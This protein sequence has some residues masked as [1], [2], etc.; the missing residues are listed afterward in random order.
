MIIALLFG[1]LLMPKEMNFAQILAVLPEG[2]ASHQSI[3]ITLVFALAERGHEITVLT[4]VVPKE[5]HEHVTIL[6][7]DTEDFITNSIDLYTCNDFSLFASFSTI[8]SLNA[9]WSE[10]FLKDANVQKLISSNAH[11]DLVLIDVLGN[12]AHKGFCYHFNA[13]C[14]TI[15]IFGANFW[16]DAQMGNPNNPSY[17]PD[18]HERYASSMSFFQRFHNSFKFVI[19]SINFYWVSLPTQTAIMQRYFPGAPDLKDLFYNVSLSLVNSH[20]TNS[21]VVANLPNVVEIGGLHVRPPQRLPQDVQKFLDD[22]KDG[23]CI[24]AL[25][26]VFSQLKQNVLWKFENESVEMPENIKTVKR[27]SQVDVLAH[28]NIRLFITHGGLLSVTEAIHFGV[29]II[30]IPIFADQK[31]NVKLAEDSGFAISLEYALLNKNVIKDAIE[32]ILTN[33]KFSIAAKTKSKIYHDQ[34][35]KP[36]DRGIYWI[37]Y[38][39]RH[40]GAHHLRSYG[41]NLYWYQY[42]MLDILAV[43]VGAIVLVSLVI[44]AIYRQTCKKIFK[45]KLD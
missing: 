18:R 25:I 24:F 13:I 40:Q 33:S 37:E 10:Q 1:L 30:G 44:K 22:S 20:F 15:N 21:L 7:V 23:L 3:G 34:L 9:Y 11:F 16:L 32:R 45:R 39:I 42:L 27:V 2:V 29:P 5:R 19:Q 31:L 4:P 12:H 36:L 26:S 43:I 38:C 17:V 14:V 6:K 28:P 41:L 35:T 8:N